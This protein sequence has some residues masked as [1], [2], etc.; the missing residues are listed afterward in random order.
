MDTVPQSSAMAIKC[1]EGQ[2]VLL[3]DAN[4][5]PKAMRRKIAC[6]DPSPNRSRGHQQAFSRL[7]D[8]V[9]PQFDR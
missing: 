3:R 8:C 5:A 7:L 1:Q 2:Q 9:K 4:H 6:S